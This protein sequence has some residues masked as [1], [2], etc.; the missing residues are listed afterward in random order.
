MILMKLEKFLEFFWKEMLYLKFKLMKRYFHLYLTFLS[1]QL[2]NDDPNDDENDTDIFSRTE[3]HKKY[4][5]PQRKQ[6]VLDESIR[7][8]SYSF[9]STLSCNTFTF[10]FNCR[11]ILRSRKLLGTVT[12][13]F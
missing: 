3:K 10:Y 12:T 9:S 1:R 7:I 4:E 8:A 11:R 6:F 13:I 2:D 5:I